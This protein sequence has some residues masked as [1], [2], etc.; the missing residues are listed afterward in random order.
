MQRRTDPDLALLKRFVASF[1]M[2][3]D[4][5]DIENASDVVGL[6][7]DTRDDNG[8]LR[9]A[10]R[11]I[12]TPPA[13]LNDVYKRL[14]GPFPTLYERLLLSYRWATVDLEVVSLLANPV[15]AARGWKVLSPRS[16]RTA[17]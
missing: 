14:P 4:R 15:S 8:L 2:S 17:A 10:L 7:G 11:A 3:D 16:S 1:G 13:V 12:E 6:V 5:V 9:W